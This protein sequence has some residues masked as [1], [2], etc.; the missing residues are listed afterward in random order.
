MATPFIPKEVDGEV[1][2]SRAEKVTDILFLFIGA[3]LLLVLLLV[4]CVYALQALAT[5]IDPKTETKYFSWISKS[6]KGHDIKDKQMNTFLNKL[7]AVQKIYDIQVTVSCD[8]TPNAFALPGGAIVL[9][10]GLLEKMKTEEGMAFVI[11]HEIGHLVQRHHMRSLG[12]GFLQMALSWVFPVDTVAIWGLF[13]KL[14]TSAYSRDHEAS[15]DSYAIATMQNI[16]GSSQG[17]E[18]F[19]EVVKS[20]PQEKFHRVFW[21]TSSHPMTDSRI[22]NIK[23]SS[24]GEERKVL[25]TTTLFQDV[26]RQV[27]RY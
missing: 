4:V 25:S 27:C 26:A 9:N 16:Y 21:L 6:M 18:E 10:T 17:S 7:T 5:K 13:N 1:N 19:F 14:F 22:E 20:L 8:S 15:A 11:A 23:E 12:M 3:S 24:H 2:V